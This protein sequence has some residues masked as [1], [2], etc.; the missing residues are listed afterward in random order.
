M[1]VKVKVVNDGSE[2]WGEIPTAHH[3]M[4]KWQIASCL[5]ITISCSFLLTELQFCLEWQHTKAVLVLTA[6]LALGRIQVTQQHN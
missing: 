2:G 3:Q 1:E 4:H 6:S 5:P